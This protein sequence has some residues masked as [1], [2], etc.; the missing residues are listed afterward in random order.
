MTVAYRKVGAWTAAFG[1]LL[2]SACA[3]P[4][5]DQLKRFQEA[6]STEQR[7]AAAHESVQCSAASEACARLY[8]EQGAICLSLAPSG[9]AS[10]R[11]ALRDCALRDFRQARSLMPS[12]MPAPDRLRSDVGLASALQLQRD[13]TGGAASRTA[14]DELL[15][16]A[17]SLG[18]APGGGAHAAYFAADAELFRVLSGEVPAPGQCA[19]L[20]A[21]ASRLSGI[22]TSDAALA[23]RL[24][25]LRRLLE[26]ARRSPAR[27]CP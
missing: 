17:E 5:L 25:Q 23:E 2:A 16:V 10:Q 27:R 24:A 8:M 11:A 12:S 18:K 15:G 7:L 3:S 4:D 19:A 1:L 9:E 22:A 26:D 14:N 21:A 20:Q 6:R 13:G